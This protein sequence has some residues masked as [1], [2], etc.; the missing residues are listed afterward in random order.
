MS[1]PLAVLMGLRKGLKL[2]RG[3]RRALIEDEQHNK[4]AGVIVEHLESVR[5]SGNRQLENR[6]RKG[7]SMYV[8]H[9]ISYY[10]ITFPL[11]LRLCRSE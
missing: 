1:L 6:V 5:R 10:L 9:N 2:C 8:G 7:I 4:L 11:S 3:T